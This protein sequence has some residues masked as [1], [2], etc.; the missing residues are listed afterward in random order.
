M[1]RRK[2]QAHPQPV[3]PIPTQQ[4]R[5]PQIIVQRIIIKL[6]G[7]HFWARLNLSGKWS[8]HTEYQFRRNNLVTDWQQGLLR[9]GINYQVN[10]RVLLRAGY[11]W[12]ETYAYGD[13]PINALGRSFTEHRLFQMVQL[14]HKEGLLELQHR[15]M[16]ERAL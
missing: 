9:V 3:D 12:A 7:T 16:L 10:P 13:F 5:S 6:A 15:F 14:S 1:R 2:E 8:L 11:A 4:L